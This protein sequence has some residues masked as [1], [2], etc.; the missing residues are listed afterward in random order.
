KY[1]PE[2]ESGDDIKSVYSDVIIAKF[3]VNNEKLKFQLPQFN[4]YRQAQTSISPLDWQLLDSKGQTIDL[5]EDTLES[6][7]V[8]IGRNYPQEARSYNTAGGVASVAVTYV[9]VNQH[10]QVVTGIEPAS[11]TVESTQGS[12]QQDTQMVDLLKTMYLKASPTD[13]EAFKLWISQQ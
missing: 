6:E 10:Q 1:Q 2:F 8:Q 13:Q 9:T 7:G 5:V 12:G 4:T 11:K 3:D